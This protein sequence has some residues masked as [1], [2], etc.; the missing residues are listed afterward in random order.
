MKVAII[1]GSSFIGQNLIKFFLKKE[2]DLTC[3]Y[4]K[5]V[6]I[7]KIFSKV[8]WKKLDLNKQKKNYFKY[9]GNPDILINLSWPDIPNYKSKNHF[10]TYNIQKKFCYNLINNG[11]TNLIFLGTCFE[12]GKKKGEVSEKSIAKPII[13]YSQ[14]KFKLLKSLLK[15]KKKKNYNLTWLRPF[16]VYG[17]NKKRETLFTI[18]KNFHKNKKI[19]KINGTLVRDFVNVNYLIDVIVKLTQ[20]KKDNGILNVCTG[21]KISIRK[22]IE[23]NLKY[24]KDIKR[25]KFCNEKPNDYEP[26]YFWGNPN[27]LKTIINKIEKSS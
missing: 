20:L 1:G 7:K 23:K 17:Q 19:L 8:T 26:E 21:K 10:K 6:E 13:P 11:L 2:I 3:T 18:I 5:N 9:L 25:I 24:K 15:L 4:N 22:F 14:S 16:Y 27:K 12:Y